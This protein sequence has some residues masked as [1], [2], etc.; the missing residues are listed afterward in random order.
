[1]GCVFYDDWPPNGFRESFF[2]STE[3]PYTINVKKFVSEDIAPLHYAETMELLVCRELSGEI[4]IN[5][6]RYELGGGQIFVI[7]P[8]TL[9]SNNIRPGEGEMYVF[10][11]SFQEL[12]HYVNIENY[13][14]LR[15]VRLDQLIYDCPDYERIHRIIQSLIEHDADR[16]V[17]IGLIMEL[18]SGLSHHADRSRNVLSGHSR[19]M[20][21]SFQELIRWT[22]DHYGEKITIDQA[23][24]RTGYSKH[25]FCNK[26]RE[27]TGMTYMNYLNTIRIFQASLMLRNGQSVKSVCEQAGFENT[28]HF[29][30]SFK[31]MQ[32]ITPYQY[33]KQAQQRK[34]EL[35]N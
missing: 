17:C 19:V 9:H 25:Y 2:Y 8:L 31:K 13:L 6:N 16:M 18:F 1:M 12:N 4:V 22:H 5:G 24:K 11:V 35:T 21:T 27:L 7:P 15:K 33:A 23:A 30:Q 26:F 34:T 14:A 20:E 29:V 3:M 32:N 10:K 28:S